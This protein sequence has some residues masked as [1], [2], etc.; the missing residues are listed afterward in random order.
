MKILCCDIVKGLKKIPEKSVACVVTSPPYWNLR[1]YGEKGQIG[2]EKTPQAYVTR[3]VGCFEGVQQVLRDDGVV[4]VNLGDTRAGKNLVGVPWMFAFA[5]RDIG[6]W[7]LRQE[8]IW[9][10][11][12]PK[13]EAMKDR[14]TTAHE[15]IFMFTKSPKYYFDADAIRT[16]TNAGTAAI[17]RWDDVIDFGK[18]EKEALP[19]WKIKPHKVPNYGTGTANRRSVWSVGVES[20]TKGKHYASYPEKLVEICILA[21]SRKGDTILDP[22]CG[23]GTTGV[24]AKKWGRDFI[25]IELNPEYAELAKNRINLGR[26]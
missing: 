17:S 11:P 21:G 23:S 12:N 10:K 13:P 16:P 19:D 5:M 9:H 6:G 14:C 24:V 8:I 25:G 4:W 7:I 18:K 22:F 2:L 3:L 15:S 1:N 20:V 26:T